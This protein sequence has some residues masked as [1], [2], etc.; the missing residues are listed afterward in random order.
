MSSRF[1]F[2]KQK[3]KSPKN[4]FYKAS[5]NPFPNPILDLPLPT[6]PLL[7]R[8]PSIVNELS[9]NLINMYNH[10]E[11]NKYSKN[12]TYLPIAPQTLNHMFTT[13]VDTIY[14]IYV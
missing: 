14:L 5:K 7:F 11:Q 2:L 1:L 12:N 4:F 10:S 13:K 8:L 9:D 6:T 3:K